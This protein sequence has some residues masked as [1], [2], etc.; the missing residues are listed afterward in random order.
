MASPSLTLKSETGLMTLSSEVE[1]QPRV[2]GTTMAMA[3]TVVDQRMKSTT[4]E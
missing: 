2:K 1:C 4:E 3:M